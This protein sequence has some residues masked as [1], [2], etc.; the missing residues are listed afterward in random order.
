MS[1]L[2]RA[3]ENHLKEV[4][5]ALFLFILGCLYLIFER[6][7]GYGNIIMSRLCGDCVR[8]FMMIILGELLWLGFL[9]ACKYFKRG[10]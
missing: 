4:A 3:L 1:M 6:Q 7:L 10:N 8:P 5:W 9:R 2:A